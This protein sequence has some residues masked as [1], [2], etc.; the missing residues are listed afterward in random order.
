MY[1]VV[2]DRFVKCHDFLKEKGIIKSTRQ[3]AQSLNYAPQS[4]SEILKK[5]RDIPIEILRKAVEL[6]DLNPNYLFSGEGE[7]LAELS[8][9]ELKTLAVVTDNEQNEKI[10]HI[11]LPCSGRICQ[12]KQRQ[13]NARR[14][15]GILLT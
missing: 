15:T 14:T 3:F 11:P 5:R 8:K 12:R 13:S 9:P 10:V 2:T 4:M 1:N 7:F 6:F